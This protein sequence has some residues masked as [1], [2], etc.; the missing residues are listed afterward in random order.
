[1]GVDGDGVTITAKRQLV[2]ADT[3]LDGD[4]LANIGYLDA[5]NLRLGVVSISGD[6]GKISAGTDSATVAIKSLTVGS[7][8][9][10]GT[11]TGAP[12][13]LSIAAGTVPTLSVKGNVAGNFEGTNIG[14]VTIGGSLLGSTIVKSATIHSSLTMG[15]VKIAGSIVGN[16]NSSA[17]ISA[18]TT[19]GSV[20]IG[21]SLN[22]GDASGLAGQ[23]TAGT[24]I[25]A[26][27]IGGD[28]TGGA[29][30]DTGKISSDGTIASVSIGGSLRGGLSNDCGQIFAG[31]KL[32]PVTI[33]GDI[34]GL[35]G[36]HSASLLSD[37]E[38]VSVSVHGSIIGGPSEQT[39]G[40]F[41]KKI[42]NVT[43]GGSLTGGLGKE[44]GRIRA[45]TSL[46]NVTIGGSIVGGNDAD[47]SDA[48][49]Q[50]QNSGT[51]D[52]GGAVG[53]VKVG[54][55][56]VGGNAF[57]AGRIDAATTIAGVNIGGSIVGGLGGFT[58]CVT[59][60]S[61]IGPVKVGFDVQGGIGA[62][63]GEIT[64]H[65][66]LTSVTIGGS[67]L[68]GQGGGAIIGAA[69]GAIVIRGSVVGG[70]SADA[71][72]IKS[73]GGLGSMQLGGSLIGGDFNNTGTITAQ[74]AG[75]I[76]IH[77][78]ILG[79]N[80]FG[81]TVSDTGSIHV[82]RLASLTVGG[83]IQAGRQDFGGTLAHSGAVQA[84]LDIGPVMVKGSLL[85]SGTTLAVITAGG[86]MFPTA[87]L[88]VAIK[89][90][91]IGGNVERAWILG[92]VN[93]NFG[94]IDGN[95]QIGAVS[96]G[97]DWIASTMESGGTSTDGFFGDANDA[98]YNGGT[99]SKI[100]SIRIK[101]HVLG[102]PGTNQTFGFFAG[103]IGSFSYNGLTLALTPGAH[104]DPF[105]GPPAHPVGPSTSTINVDGFAVHVYE[106]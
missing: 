32:G 88:D 76:T 74:G 30:N 72:Y 29:Y 57:F 19:L 15:A 91:T 93:V 82:K 46:G 2:N 90:V 31:V 6:V 60:G 7:H 14:T 85:G 70:V 104:N 106:I 54:G 55:G 103:Q 73:S 78:D 69:A 39:G 49:V 3:L 13:I 45:D 101:G 20:T 47:L 56:L 53:T 25:G 23:I 80:A 36:M 67:L 95:A 41:S 92:G 98:E 77:G 35:G 97:G 102:E 24:S 68:G 66:L 89:S 71:G 9:E 61:T 37:T 27:K 22:G 44:S 11:A 33:G 10:F 40:I 79:G 5:H 18:G 17:V 59:S 63:G 28:L 81:T 84:D 65:G 52:C 21:G 86:A 58:G 1:M 50:A 99:I 96:V 38:I 43:I 42:G 34:D 87:T 8:G 75:A 62:G 100:A 48:V 94:A 64:S 4:G 12:D 83:S 26:V 16:A 105:A 51:I